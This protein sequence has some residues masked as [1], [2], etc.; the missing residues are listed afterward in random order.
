MISARKLRANRINCRASTGP[1]T[2]AGRATSA[3]NARRHGLRIPVLSDP[4]LSAAVEVMAQKIARTAD[5]ELVAL[6]RRIAEAEVDVL[7][8]R[9]VR[10]DLM[11]GVLT[12]G[13]N[14][15][16]RRPQKASALLVRMLKLRRGKK[17][18]LLL[19]ANQQP[20]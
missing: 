11:S 4:A 19:A 10:N 18:Q 2:V 9:R 6:A 16:P 14:H 17:I 20:F 12:I 13:C 8:V 15:L 1:K 3:G 7:R 5:P